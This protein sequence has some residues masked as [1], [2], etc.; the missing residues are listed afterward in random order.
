MDASYSS[1][2]CLDSVDSRRFWIFS[3]TIEGK[4]QERRKR[5]LG[6][7][8]CFGFMGVSRF[9]DHYPSAGVNFLE[10]ERERDFWYTDHF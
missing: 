6:I 1:P 2:F 7:H 8:S 3:L 4:N 5:S 9:P 10:R